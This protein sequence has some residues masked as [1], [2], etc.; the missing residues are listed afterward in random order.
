METKNETVRVRFAPSPTGYLHLGSVRTALINYIYAKQKNGIFILRIEDTDP[1]RNF[2]PR[3]SIIIEDLNWLDL[4]YNEGP[5]LQ[6]E[7][8]EIYQEYLDKLKEKPGKIY[9]CFCTI[10]ELEKIRSRQIALKKPPRYEQ[11]C[12]KLTNNQ[13]EEKLKAN[14]PFIWRFNL[15]KNKTIEISDL[16]RGKITFNLKNFSDFPL[17][18]CDGSFTFIF[19][20]FVDD[21]EMKITDVFRGEDHISNTALQAALYEAFD[22]KLP[23]FYHMPIIVTTTGKKLSKR[24]FG[25]RLKDLKDAGFLPEAINNYLAI[26]GSSFAQEI[27][28]LNQIIK[29]FNFNSISSTGTITYDLEKLKWVNHKWILKLAPQDLALRVRDHLEKAYP[30]ASELSNKDLET[31]ISAVQKELFTLKDSVEALKFYFELPKFNKETLEQ[32]NYQE[33][34][35]SLKEI[36]NLLSTDSKIL[37]NPDETLN[38]IKEIAKKNNTPLKYIFKILRIALTGEPNGPEIKELI[39][40]LKPQEIIIRLKTLVS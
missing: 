35:E 9:R 20:N 14:T 40:I 23:K 37:E 30:Q 39:K 5:Y 34:K 10:E 7:R 3:G 36:F 28:D 29:N 26:I 4:K 32:Y 21:L 16:I 19:A 24:D 13:I 18:R 11:T 17:T 27:M 2:D 31:L 15:D 22:A 6:S 12:T 8:T 38:I 25:F 1:Q 33:T